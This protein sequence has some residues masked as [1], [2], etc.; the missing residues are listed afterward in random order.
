[1]RVTKMK[2]HDVICFEPW[3]SFI[4]KGIK[5]IEGRRDTDSYAN[6]KKGDLITFIEPEKNTKCLVLVKSIVRYKNLNDFLTNEQ[7]QFILPGIKT[8]EQAKKIYESF[9]EKEELEAFNF[10]AIHM[11]I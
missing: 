7:L 5:T 10:L 8:K 3:F 6:I 11:M 4:Q 2:N 1:M 9:W